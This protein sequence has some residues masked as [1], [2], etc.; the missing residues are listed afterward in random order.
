MYPAALSL[1]LPTPCQAEDFVSLQLLV[2]GSLT[3]PAVGSV[4]ESPEKIR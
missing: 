3:P 4:Q 2:Q 1:S